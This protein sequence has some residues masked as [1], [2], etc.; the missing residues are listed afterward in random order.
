LLVPLTV[1]SW[2][3]FEALALEPDDR[4]DRPKTSKEDKSAMKTNRII[5]T[6]D[7]AGVGNLW[8]MEQVLA[9]GRSYFEV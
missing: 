9:S 7:F 6:R 8:V 2:R 5:A 1:R 3:P 4:F